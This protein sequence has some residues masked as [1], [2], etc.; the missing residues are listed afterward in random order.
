MSLIGDQCQHPWH[1]NT[2]TPK[3]LLSMGSKAVCNICYKKWMFNP[4]CYDCDKSHTTLNAVTKCDE[5]GNFRCTDSNGCVANEIVN[6][7]ESVLHRPE[8]KYRSVSRR[9]DG[10]IKCTV[11]DFKE[12]EIIYSGIPI[13]DV[14][15]GNSLNYHENEQIDTQDINQNDKSDDIYKSRHL[16]IPNNKITYNMYNSNNLQ[17]SHHIEE[18]D[19][20]PSIRCIDIYSIDY[21]CNVL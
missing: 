18:L 6:S 21:S 12:L 14:L 5:D 4:T 8:F 16:N 3:C 1:E 15:Y 9:E 10:K 20:I 17:S 13:L 2:G 7:C 19:D 11:C